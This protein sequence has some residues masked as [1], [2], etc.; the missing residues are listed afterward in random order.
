MNWNH[1]L[2]E[3]PRGKSILVYNGKNKK[4]G[5]DTYRS[6]YVTDWVWLVTESKEVVKGHWSPT[7]KH[8]AGIGTK[9]RVIAW[10]PYVKPV[11]EVI[12]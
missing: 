12:E 2:E 8:W 9:E 10:Q 5:E 7:R 11:Y 1:N 3:A 4:T 6:E